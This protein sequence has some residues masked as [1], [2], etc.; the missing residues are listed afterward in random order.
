MEQTI[1]NYNKLIQEFNILR[2]NYNNVDHYSIN[3]FGLKYRT[4]TIHRMY[5]SPITFLNDIKYVKK[6]KI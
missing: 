3:Y 2:H 1:L 6:Y 5:F 4:C